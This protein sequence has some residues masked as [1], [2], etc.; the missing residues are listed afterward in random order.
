[1]L[2]Q[3]I[4]GWWAWYYYLNPFAWSVYGLC[5]SQLGHDFHN[6]VNTYGCARMHTSFPAATFY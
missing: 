2:L 5:A 1:M 4:P 3:R 6:T